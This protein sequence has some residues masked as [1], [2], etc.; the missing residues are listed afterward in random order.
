MN[1]TPDRFLLY[2]IDMMGDDRKYSNN[3]TAGV[4]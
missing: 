1:A 4:F 3:L 2:V